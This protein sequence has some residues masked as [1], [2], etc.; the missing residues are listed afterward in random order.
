MP[1]VTELC[2]E[3]CVT[4]RGYSVGRQSTMSYGR[5]LVTA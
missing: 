4:V 2:D 5:K 1:T 3:E